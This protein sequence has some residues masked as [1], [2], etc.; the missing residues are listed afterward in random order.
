[1]AEWASRR[2]DYRRLLVLLIVLLAGDPAALPV[3][4]TLD[5]RALPFRHRAVGECLVFHPLHPLLALFEPRSFRFGQLAGRDALIDP[6]VLIRLTR[7]A[8]NRLPVRLRDVSLRDG[9]LS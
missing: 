4:R 6:A 8:S 2:F 3:L 1:M 7:H 9:H 5:P